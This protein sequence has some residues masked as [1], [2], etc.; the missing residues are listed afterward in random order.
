MA[1]KQFF[2]NSPEKAEMSFIDHLEELRWHIMR[3]V[4]ALLI[5][6]VVVFVNINFF[7]DGIVMGPTHADFVTYRV[8]CDVSHRVG[9]GASMC[10]E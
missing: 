10:L 4:I 1:L 9:L 2:K 3:S 5:G 8:L 7:F 6:M